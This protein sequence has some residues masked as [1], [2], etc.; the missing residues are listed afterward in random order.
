[1]LPVRQP[2]LTMMMSCLMV[3]TGTAQAA[4][5]VIGA[6][7]TLTNGGFVL[8][9]TDSLTLNSG[10][11][12]APTSGNPGVSYT[13]NSTTTNLL[14]TL[15]VDDAIAVSIDGTGTLLNSRGTIRATGTGGRG[16]SLCC[17]GTSINHSGTLTTTN[18]FGIISAGENISVISTGWVEVHGSGSVGILMEGSSST[19]TL[20][21]YLASHDDLAVRFGPGE[22]V[23]PFGLHSFT[24]N[25]ESFVIGG[26]FL[27]GN[28][29]VTINTG[30]APSFHYGFSGAPWNSVTVNGGSPHVISGTSIASFDPT[31]FA[32]TETQMTGLGDLAFETS[33]AANAEEN[34][35]LSSKTAVVRTSTQAAATSLGSWFSLYGGASAHGRGTTTLAYQNSLSGMIGGVQSRDRNGN[36]LSLFLGAGR[37]FMA[38]DGLFAGSHRI[39]T[40]SGYLGASGRIASDAGTLDYALIG[41]VQG[42]SSARTI[43]N[44]LL[45]LGLATARANYSSVFVAP[46][47]SFSRD[48]SGIGGWGL[49]ARAGLG[50]TFGLV[51]GYSETGAAAASDVAARRFGLAT[52]HADLTVHRQ[53]GRTRVTGLVGVTAR[54]NLGAETITGEMLGTV[55]SYANPG[56]GGLAGQIGLSLDHQFNANMSAH[57]SVQAALGAGGLAAQ[58]GSASLRIGF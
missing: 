41:G 53:I 48:L 15:N 16:I 45:A 19:L 35:R 52:S 27:D 33:R 49:R 38:A 14:G 2:C 9:D 23:D 4:D 32:A 39:S 7:S 18:G 36:A 29:D 6:G 22:I 31:N 44:P 21:G 11:T 20:S 55:W 34:G 58:K 56:T 37:D 51:T 8:N 50:L 40:T 17:D 1:M 26:F 57:V 46:R 28:V 25:S 12:L 5:F 42:H 43:N 30:P 24:I 13:A 47:V 54:N 3:L 10:V